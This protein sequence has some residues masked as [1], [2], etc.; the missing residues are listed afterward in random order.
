MRKNGLTISEAERG[1]PDPTTGRQASEAYAEVYAKH[2]RETGD[3]LDYKAWNI[4]L[5]ALDALLTDYRLL[6]VGCA[7]GG[8]LR[9]IKNHAHVV[10]I[11]FA[12]TTVTKARELCAEFGIRRV[13]FVVSLF[14]TYPADQLFD[15]VRLRGTFGAYQPW[16]TSLGAIDKTR[17]ILKDGGIAI[18]SHYRPRHFIHA[19]KAA[20]IP[21]RT[22]AITPRRFRKMWESRGFAQVFSIEMP[23][24]M[25]TFFRKT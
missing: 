14:E 10:G 13:E 17:D 9:L 11:D 1:R 2:H 3:T 24:A 18:A 8:Y 16:A 22:L 15:A 23:H 4:D 19:L 7:T 25:I 12:E 20:L 21:K 6:D 5:L